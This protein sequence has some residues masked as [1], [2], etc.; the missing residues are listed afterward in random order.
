MRYFPQVCLL[1]RATTQQRHHAEDG[2]PPE[3]SRRI[4]AGATSLC[5]AFCGLYRLLSHSALVSARSGNL[6]GVQKGNVSQRSYNRLIQFIV[7]FFIFFI[8]G[9]GSFCFIYRKL[10]YKRTHHCK[11]S[12]V[13]KVS[14]NCGLFNSMSVQS[15]EYLIIELSFQ[16]LSHF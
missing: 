16:L 3:T 8:G 7:A 10:T 5:P 9:L 1:C 13:S 4:N 11:M 15:E 6:V 12:S 14:A 2:L